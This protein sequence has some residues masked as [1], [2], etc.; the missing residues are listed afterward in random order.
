MADVARRSAFRQAITSFMF[1]RDKGLVFEKLKK[2]HAVL[3]C[4]HGV[5]GGRG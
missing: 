1:D 4:R 2:F 5:G 3:I